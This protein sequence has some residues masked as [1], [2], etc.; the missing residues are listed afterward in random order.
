MNQKKV[1]LPIGTVVLLKDAT[2]KVVIIGYAISENGSNEVWDYL[3]CAYP[4]G[5]ISSDSNL[6]FN[7][8]QIGK[9]VFMGYADEEGEKFSKD[10]E[11]N[12]R[13]LGK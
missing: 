13:L 8:E 6:L 10:L 3:G 5:V 11:N 2:R 1:Y 9:I 12:M 4:V 7:K